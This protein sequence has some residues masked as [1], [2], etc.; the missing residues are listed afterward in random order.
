MTQE[1]DL[2]AQRIRDFELFKKEVV[3]KRLAIGGFPDYLDGVPRRFKKM[4]I[5]FQDNVERWYV[6]DGTDDGHLLA[7]FKTEIFTDK[8]VMIYE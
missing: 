5:E 6:D 3:R 4:H 1:F 8:I 2:K 7:T